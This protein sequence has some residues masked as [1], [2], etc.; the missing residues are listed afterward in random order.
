MSIMPSD[1]ATFTCRR[2]QRIKPTSEFPLSKKAERGYES[3][4]KRCRQERKV[5]REA[6]QRVGLLPQ[7]PYMARRTA[8]TPH[9]HLSAVAEPPPT[10]DWDTIAL[11]MAEAIATVLRRHFS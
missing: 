10:T 8:P 9:A 7:P 2:C 4:C 3:T 1:R 6:A 5:A 11:D